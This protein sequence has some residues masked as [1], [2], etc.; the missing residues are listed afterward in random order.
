MNVSEISRLARGSGPT[1][2][3]DIS[4]TLN[5]R[6][7][8]LL[9]FEQGLQHMLVTHTNLIQIP[10]DGGHET[11]LPVCIANYRWRSQSKGL[12]KNLCCT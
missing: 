11:L 7:L 10:K 12:N 4:Y 6:V 1:F 5:E 8:I 3:D 9:P 2:K